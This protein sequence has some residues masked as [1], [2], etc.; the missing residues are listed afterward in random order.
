MARHEGKTA[1]EYSSP[2]FHSCVCLPAGARQP[3]STAFLLKQNQHWQSQ[4]LDVPY[5]C[6]RSCRGG[7]GG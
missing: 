3:G 5:R 6:C 2:S 7:R 4:H 1:Q